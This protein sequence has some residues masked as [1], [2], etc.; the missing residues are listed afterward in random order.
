MILSGILLMLLVLLTGPLWVLL[1]GQLDLNTHWSTADRRSMGTAPSPETFF[2]AS[3]RIYYARSFNWRGAFAVHSWIAL[4]EKN[5]KS[6]QNFQVMG[7]RLFGNQSSV[8][9]HR[10]DPDRYWYGEKAMLLGEIT[11]EAAE[12]AIPKIREASEQYPFAWI[13]KVWP[14]PNSNSYISYLIRSAGNIPFG[15]PPTAIGK[16]YTTDGAFFS[17]TPSL[18]GWQFSLYGLIGFILSKSEGLRFQLLGLEFGWNPFK[19]ELYWPGV[20]IFNYQ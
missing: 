10:G 11:G 9:V 5:G 12:L 19:G 4:K 7:W 14:G 1:S 2:E 15:L 17:K 8:D 20:G 6:Y 3:V 13:Y 16:D 18:T